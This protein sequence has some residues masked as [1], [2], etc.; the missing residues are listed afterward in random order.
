MLRFGLQ[1][2]ALLIPVLCVAANPSVDCER[3]I[4]VHCGKAP[5]AAF[6][7][8]GSLWLSF[9]QGEFVYVQSSVDQGLSFSVPVKVNKAPESVYSDGENRPKIALGPV[10]Q[11]YLSWT[12][13]TGGR[14]N[15]D[16]RFSRS[17]DGGKHFEAVQT[18]NDD[19]AGISQRFDALHVGT[20]GTVY[21][22]WLDKRDGVKARQQQREYAGS[23]V[24]FAVSTDQG[25]SFSDNHKLSDHS[26]ECCRLAIDSAGDDGA[27]LLW[28]QLFDV[29]T[30]DHAIAT[31]HKTGV[32]TPVARASI[33][34]WQIDA[35]P[36]HGPDVSWADNGDY[37]LAWFTN[38]SLN[39]G[40]YYGRYN[41]TNAQ[42]HK[43]L[44]MD[45]RPGA[46][47][48][49]LLAKGAR[50]YFLWKYFDGSQTQLLLSTS[51]DNGGQ[52]ST[53]RPVASTAK[54]SDHPIIASHRQRVFVSW[55]NDDGYQL[56][57]LDDHD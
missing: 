41:V 48:P 31:V 32:V 5:S 22:V 38:G 42:L 52:W 15:G 33:D 34:D 4:S 11:I 37:H 6:D 30:R 45:T 47:H 3:Q 46:S 35:C 49:Q 13:K 23:A 19:Q 54:G 53:P 25:A 12:Q 55:L 44:A 8:Q 29:N 39:Q 10:G 26:C 24:Y 57:A 51:N 36:H 16:I 21:L 20:D 50:L 27:V 40:I 9:V 17:L 43:S 7:S 14:F 2:L 28:R 1:A 18:V 56:V